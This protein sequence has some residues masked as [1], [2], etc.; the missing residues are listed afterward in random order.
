MRPAIPIVRPCPACRGTLVARRCPTAHRR[1]LVCGCGWRGPLPEAL[2]LRLAGH[3][4]LPLVFEERH[5][6]S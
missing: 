5:E 3:E 6:S 1:M 2:R 4:E